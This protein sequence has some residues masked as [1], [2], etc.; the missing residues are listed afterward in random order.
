[1]LRIPE[2]VDAAIAIGEEKHVVV[3]VPRDLI[4]LKFELLLSFR[5]MRLCINEGN[6]IIF[7]PYCNSLPIRAPANINVL[8]CKKRHIRN[9]DQEEFKQHMSFYNF[10]TPTVPV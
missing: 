6:H 5:P 8:P 1:M 2:D 9:M 10:L 4:H 7:V 3:I